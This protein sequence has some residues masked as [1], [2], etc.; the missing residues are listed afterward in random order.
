MNKVFFSVIVP[1][2]NVSKYL[3]ECIDSIISQN[4]EDFEI[5]LIND[6][7]TDNS[8]EICETYA[9]KHSNIKYYS[10]ENGGLSLARNFGID[11]ADGD[12]LLFIDSD[13]FLTDPDFLAKIFTLI[14]NNTCDFV[15][16]LPEEYNGDLSQK[17]ITHD[18]KCPFLNRTVNARDAIDYIYGE[19]CY[20]TMAQTKIIRR[21][22]LL[23]NE[24]FFKPGIFH[25]DDEWI[26]RTLLS[27]PDVVISDI[28]GYGYRHR[29]DSII[30]TKN[31]Q[32]IFKKCCDRITIS[33][34][35]LNVK[36]IL[37]HK[38]C[39]THFAY[40]YMHSFED[41]KSCTTCID[42]FMDIANSLNVI[43]KMK[44]SL[45]KKH[46]FF[47]YCKRIFGIR[48]ANALILK[49]VRDNS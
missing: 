24:L 20:N 38:T 42:A 10:K 27:Y 34:E 43:D 47:Y 9:E 15:I 39:L 22:Y 1:L 26:A 36:N 11:K 28:A 44:Y 25:E 4:F 5:I 45:S 23:E 2:Y 16:Y 6:G 7:S 21:K 31:E 32:K 29:E 41:I 12:Y 49:T 46:R 48:S 19:D 8:G 30:S 3:Q 17:I 40:Y 13:D 33:D 35:I 37:G 18:P 14:K